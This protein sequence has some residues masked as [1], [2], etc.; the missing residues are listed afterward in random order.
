MVPPLGWNIILFGCFPINVRGMHVVKFLNPIWWSLIMSDG[1]R[2]AAHPIVA[3]SPCPTFPAPG[4]FC[5]SCIPSCT[6]CRFT[7]V[8][9]RED[10]L[11]SWYLPPGSVGECMVAF[12]VQGAAWV[13]GRTSRANLGVLGTGYWQGR[14]RWWWADPGR[15]QI[16]ALLCSIPGPIFLCNAVVVVVQY[17]WLQGAVHGGATGMETALSEAHDPPGSTSLSSTLPNILV[18]AFHFQ[19]D[20]SSLF[21]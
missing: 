13:L 8:G 9:R 18:R 10:K 7:Q 21:S 12:Q 6:G 1:L 11:M 16:Q 19:S 15:S 5:A 3:C 14:G 20:L 17:M 2:W 4:R